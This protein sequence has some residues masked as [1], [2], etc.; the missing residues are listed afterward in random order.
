MSPKM[1]SRPRINTRTDSVTFQMLQHPAFVQ[2]VN[3]AANLKCL[4]AIKSGRLRVVEPPNIPTPTRYT[5]RM[6]LIDDPSSPKLT[7]IF[8]I[9]GI[10]TNEIS[11]QIR[12]S[13]LVILGERK[14]PHFSAARF[15]GLPQNPVSAANLVALGEMETDDVA[16]RRVRLPVQELRF[17][18]F[19]RSIRIPDGIRESDV[20]ATLQ[21]GMLTVTWP[22]SPV[23]TRTEHS[24]PTRAS[25][26]SSPTQMPSPPMPMM[27]AGTALQ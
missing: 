7:A 13:Q 12:D 8:E 2:A 18:T 23:I 6:D 11:L 9:P 15:D 22:R 27:T 16:A 25:N 21:D 20:K 3:R 1:T 17:G 5:P 19:S 26:S 4:E 10:Q 24:M 14:S